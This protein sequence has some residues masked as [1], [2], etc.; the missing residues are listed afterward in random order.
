MGAP[1]L[2]NARSVSPDSA[3]FEVDDIAVR[4]KVVPVE[5][6]HGDGDV[7]AVVRHTF[8]V[9]DQVVDCTHCERLAACVFYMEEM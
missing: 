2:R 8:K 7:R 5:L 3:L 6:D 9:R 4:V 1:F